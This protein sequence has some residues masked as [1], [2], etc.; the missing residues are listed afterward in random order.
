V[1]N[2]IWCPWRI[3]L[4]K[5][6]SYARTVE[7]TSMAALGSGRDLGLKYTAIVIARKLAHHHH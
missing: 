3:I 5:W 2:R 1:Q 7:R 4:F 6:S